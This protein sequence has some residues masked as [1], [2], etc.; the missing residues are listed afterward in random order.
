MS[1]DNRLGYLSLLIRKQT[2]AL[3][4]KLNL[5]VRSFFVILSLYL[6]FFLPETEFGYI[7]VQ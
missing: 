3:F 7:R 6:E 4:W 1:Q 2:F 5:T